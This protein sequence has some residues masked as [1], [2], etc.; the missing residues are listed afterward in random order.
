[1]QNQVHNPTFC[2]LQ[3]VFDSII[4]ILGGV[5]VIFGCFADAAEEDEDPGAFFYI[6][7]FLQL[8]YIK[9]VSIK[10]LPLS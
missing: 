10:T 9:T 4:L 6:L 1:M 8:T 3:K 2:F 7:L 5:L